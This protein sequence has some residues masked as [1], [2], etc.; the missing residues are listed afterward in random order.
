MRILDRYIIKPLV[1]TFLG[2]L[3]IFIF[4]YVISDALSRLDDILKHHVGLTFMYHYYL[5]SLPIIATQT[6]PIALLLST[7]YVFGKLNRDNELIAMRSSGLSLWQICAP[8]IAIGL[9]LSILIFSTNEKIIPA[10][11]LNA[12]K[13]KKTLDGEKNTGPKEVVHNLTFYGLENRLF[14]INYFD[15]KTN[16]MEGITILE[17]DNQQNLTAK[18]T[19]RRADYKDKLWFFYEFNRLNFD[20]QGQVSDDA[21][22]RQEEITDITETPQD[23]L[24]QKKH[25]ELMTI[26]QLEDYIWKLRKSGARPAVRNLLVE[27]H[28]RYASSFSSLILILIGIPFSFKIRKR[29]NIFSS[30][31]ICIGIS[32]LYYVLTGISLALG[33]SGMLFPFLSAW[34]APIGFSIAA[35]RMIQESA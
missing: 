11:R 10:A 14:F 2:C 26:A 4:L 13:M 20:D 24:Q 28:Q 5:A 35:L 1:S 19:A 32:F 22:Y 29:A 34:I 30:F 31:G 16:T 17:H 15:S 6:A 27:L 21:I 8:S 12:D 9:S 25:Q 33:K 3:F 18:I 7:I 23:F